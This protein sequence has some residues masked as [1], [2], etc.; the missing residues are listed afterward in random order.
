MQLPIET[1]MKRYVGKA[2]PNAAINPKTH[3]LEQLY[4]DLF[5]I[6]TKKNKNITAYVFKGVR[7]AASQSINR[8]KKSTQLWEIRR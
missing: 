3:Y 7:H 6:K 8:K 1:Y 4:P 5:A 2:Q